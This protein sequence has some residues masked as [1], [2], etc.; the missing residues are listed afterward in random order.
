MVAMADAVLVIDK[1]KA[2][3]VKKIVDLLGKQGFSQALSSSASS[4]H[5]VG[6]KLLSWQM[7]I[8]VRR[9]HL[10]PKTQMS[11]QKHSRRSENWVVTSGVAEVQIQDRLVRLETNDSLDIPAGTVHQLSN[12]AD[13][14]LTLIEVRTGAYLGEDDVER[15]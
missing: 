11:L 4:G 14:A 3:S 9:V 6:S 15:L 1:N 8:Q 10:Y 13:A 7:N 2:Q 12:P 5:G